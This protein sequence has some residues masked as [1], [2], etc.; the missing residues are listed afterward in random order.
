MNDRLKN[1]YTETLE[2]KHKLDFE[3]KGYEEVTRKFAL[4][5]E[6]VTHPYFCEYRDKVLS[7][8]EECPKVANDSE[9]HRQFDKTNNELIAWFVGLNN[10][11]KLDTQKLLRE[12]G[13]KSANDKSYNQSWDNWNLAA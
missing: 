4:I 6:S 12:Y 2:Q 11:E 3:K 9:F 13:G 5:E 1:P 7:L 10:K 8:L